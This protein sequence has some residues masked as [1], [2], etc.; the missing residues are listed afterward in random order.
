[1]VLAYIQFATTLFLFG[2]LF[3]PFAVPIDTVPISVDRPACP[4][5]HSAA[6][7]TG[8]MLNDKTPVGNATYDATT[9][10]LE[11]TVESVALP[12]GTRLAVLIGD[13]KIGDME[14]LK[15][16]SARVVLIR[17]LTD[18][19]RVRVIAGDR[20]VVSA[21][22][23]CVNIPASAPT[24]TPSPTPS[25]VPSVSPGVSPS[26]SPSPTASPSPSPAPTAEPTPDPMPKPSPA[27]TPSPR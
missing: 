24:V 20:P 27:V 21:N 18:Q 25:P 9:K 2:V 10:S 23:Q 15:Q 13:D 7:L 14:P 22:L 3:L 16:G 19:A 26:P 4:G 11:V 6:K 8:W 17:Q 12:D 1:M 5:G